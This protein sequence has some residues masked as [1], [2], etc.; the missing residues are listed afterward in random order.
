MKRQ[1]QRK[2]ALAAVLT[3][4]TLLAGCGEQPG[5]SEA[6][7]LSNAESTE[8]VNEKTQSAETLTV[9]C[10]EG[11]YSAVSINDN[12]PIWQEVEK[13]TGIHIN[14]EANSDYDTAM[15]PR[16]ASGADLPDIMLITPSWSN[17]GV[18]KLGRDGIILKL[19]DLIEEHAPDIQQVLIEN[20]DLKGL[21]TAPDGNIYSIAD[22]PKFVND[23]VVQNT[24]FV[25]QDWLDKLDLSVPETIDDWYAI[26]KAFKE[27]DPNGNGQPDEVP[28]SSC[29]IVGPLQTFAS[30]F[31]LPSGGTEWWHDDNGDIFHVY[32][33]PQFKEF[34]SEMNKWY[35]EG[36]IDQEISR[37]EPNFQSL[38]AT[39]VVGCFS[40]LSERQIQYNNILKTAGVS[41]ASHTLVA[42]P[43]D[44][45]GS[46]QILKRPQT[47]N[48]Y[49]ITRNC[50]NPE[51]AI[52]WMNFVWGSEEGITLTEFGIEGLTYNVVDGQ[53][54]YTDYVLNNPEGLDPYNTLRSLGAANTIL[55]RTP[56]E[57]Y[58]GLNQ[59][60]DAIPFAQSLLPNRV[61]PFPDVMPDENEQK[62]IDRIQPDISTY[63]EECL[64]KFITGEM[65]IAQFDS[66][67]STLEGMGLPE[68]LQVKQAQYDRAVSTK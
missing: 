44:A 59:D 27:S 9:S 35:S 34:L 23:M 12:L 60:S 41:E 22:C 19:D 61:E 64:T 52:R 30:A 39:N 54:K 1:F 24:L 33:S 3:A 62:I 42:P 48:H 17:A 49:G 5:Q 37:D 13:R 36:L 45:N 25:R 16:I 47:W 18:F 15:Q 58:I 2:A 50:K 65:T 43:A 68:L 26:L 56:P 7:P 10:L 40:T 67:V 46:L 14:W 55:V 21:L 8:A 38:C 63:N 20:P 32:S 11:W 4:I 31:G 29:G 53:K 6:P 57:E 51:T 66:Y 28:F